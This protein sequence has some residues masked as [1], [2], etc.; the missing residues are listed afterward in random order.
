MTVPIGVVIVLGL[1]IGSFL[2]VCIWRLPRNESVVSPRS[3]CPACQRPIRLFDNIPIVSFLLLRGRCRACGESISW[4]YP[5]VELANGVGYGV[6]VWRF[7]A[8]WE[9]AI[10]AV[11]Y[12]AL[13]VVTVIDLDH[14]IIPDRITLPGMLIGLAA[15]AA[16]LPHGFWNGL[17]GL[18]GGG[19]LFYLVAVASGG[20]MGGGDI[21]LIAMIGAFL[22][23]KLMLL[24]IFLAALS[25]AVVGIYLMIAAGRS[26]KS[27]VPFGPFLSLGAIV[28]VLYGHEI[29]SWYLSWS[30]SA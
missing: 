25:G 1:L 11:L 18:L 12:S 14:Q 27:Q 10:Y 3:R 4:R 24:T 17:W 6:L 22:G 8:A 29:V 9:T 26:R 21:K 15:A 30:L 16:V 28:A 19:A 2:N 13:L 7:G 20:G 23:W 5:L